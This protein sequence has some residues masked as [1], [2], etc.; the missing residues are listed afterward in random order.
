MR[1]WGRGEGREED[2]ATEDMGLGRVRKAE[3]RRLEEE[4][5]EGGGEGGGTGYDGVG[6]GKCTAGRGTR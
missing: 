1:E 3:R 4:R 2:E 6:G 5:T